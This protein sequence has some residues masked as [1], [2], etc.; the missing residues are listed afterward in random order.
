[1][2]STRA[3]GRGIRAHSSA[4][5]AGL[6]GVA[7]LALG[8]HVDAQ[9]R[10]DFDGDGF[11]DLAIGIRHENVGTPGFPQISNG[12]AVCVIHGSGTGLSDAGSQL[13]HQDV[14]TVQEV[15][16]E[17]DNFGGTLAVGDFDGDGYSDLAIGSS[18]SIGSATGA[19]AVNVLYGTPS[20]LSDVGNQLWSQDSAA[21]ED[22]PESFEGF[23]NAL[24]V[25]DFDADGFDDL[26]IG[27]PGENTSSLSGAGAVC[28]LYGTAAG[29]SATRSQ[30]WH[31]DSPG[32]LDAAEA[33]DFFGGGLAAGDF[34]GDG[35]ADL[36]IG[37]NLEDIG[38]VD[39][40]GALNVLFGTATGLS[41]VGNQLWHQDVAGVP[42][43]AESFDGFGRILAAG[44]FDGDGFVDLALGLTGESIGGIGGAGAVCILFGTATGLTASGSEFWH[45][46]SA[47]V[48]DVAE[49][50]DAFGAALAAGD[51]TGDG[52]DDLI[53]GVP[54][55]NN[56]VN[57]AG[58]IHA[59][60]G[61]SAGLSSVKLVR[62]MG[63]GGQFYGSS[64]GR[65]LGTGD[66]NGDGLHDVAVGAPY[67]PVGTVSEAGQV[68]VFASRKA[69]PRRFWHQ[70][71]SGIPDVVEPLDHFGFTLS[72]H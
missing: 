36:A 52:R 51:F 23:G 62:A 3:K 26:A 7:L 45:Q 43:A 48:D 11:D 57:P 12:G 33:G 64:F 16:E 44:E 61:T 65:A 19:G 20:G 13:W 24:S 56:G 35:F 28:V 37:A 6:C 27:V 55:E 29:L 10:G 41:D 68:A 5:M 49:D 32:V 8:S 60:R 67:S 40:A 2:D 71:T 21:L 1:M 72:G 54:Q 4:V 17:D 14:G 39:S 70:D 42:D 58:A 15:A 50:F 34:N 38:T 69:F 25:G 22:E 46:D 59:F 9:S 66:Y 30:L 31:Q 18:E 53:V 47:G 63:E